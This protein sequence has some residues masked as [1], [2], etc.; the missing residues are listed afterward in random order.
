MNA[1]MMMTSA[2]IIS[3]ES[4][5]AQERRMRI[6]LILRDEER[7]DVRVKGTMYYR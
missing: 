3:G 7:S 2:V 6:G 4:Y 1:M 5:S